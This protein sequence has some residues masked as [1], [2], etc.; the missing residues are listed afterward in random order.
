MGIYRIED[1]RI[2]EAHWIQAHDFGG[3]LDKPEAVV[4]HYTAGANKE[5]DLRTLTRDDSVYVSCH[6]HIGRCGH[7]TQ[8]VPFNTQAWHA[9]R[10]EWDGR[11]HLNKWSI[12]IELSNTGPLRLGSE[13]R[14]WAW[15]KNLHGTMVSKD[16][17]IFHGRHRNPACRHEHW[18]AYTTEQHRQLLSVLCALWRE[19]PSLH[20]ILGHDDVAPDRKIDPGPAFP[21]AF[22]RK[23]V[24]PRLEKARGG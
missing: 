7:L 12:G 13:G 20:W 23:V 11:K 16:T 18:E 10:S 3:P 22:Y 1:N 8:M 2:L 14:Y 17:P 5:A 9:G 24:L 15:P 4:I 6:L 19:Y 21:M